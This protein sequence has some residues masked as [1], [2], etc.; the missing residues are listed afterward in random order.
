VAVDLPPSYDDICTSEGNGDGPPPSLETH[1]HTDILECE[2]LVF[3][4][5]SSVDSTKS[6]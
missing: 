1:L 3:S 2:T 4:G 6:T 5:K